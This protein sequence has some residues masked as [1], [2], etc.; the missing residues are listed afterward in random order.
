MSVM[1]AWWSL[2]Q[3]ILGVNQSKAARTRGLSGSRGPLAWRGVW[4]GAA[5]RTGIAQRIT[6]TR[7]RFTVGLQ[8]RSPPNAW[9]PLGKARELSHR[10][11]RAGPAWPGQ[12]Y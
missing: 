8:G 5:E 9:Q 2:T 1:R 10:S 11:A 7:A 3:E 12:I 6:Q 4:G